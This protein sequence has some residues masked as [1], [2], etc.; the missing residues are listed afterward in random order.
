LEFFTAFKPLK[1]ITSAAQF[2][3]E[4]GLS[5]AMHKPLKEF[6]SGMRQR[7]KLGLAITADTDFLLLDEPSSHL[8]AKAIEWYNLLV[9]KYAN[10]RIIFVASNKEESEISFCNRRVDI[11]D[12]KR[13][14][15]QA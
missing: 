14:D 4:I 11:V 7:V 9:Q 12:F 2:A 5:H 8:D 3:E 10:D 1:N 15:V 13:S 6:S